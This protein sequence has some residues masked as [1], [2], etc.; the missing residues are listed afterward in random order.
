MSLKTS[1]RM[2][3]TLFR[4]LSSN[5]TQILHRIRSRKYNP[6]KELRDVRPEGS[7]QY[8]DEIIIPQDDLYIISWE[9]EF[10]DF[11]TH[12][13]SNNTSDTSPVDSDQRD[14]IITD[15]DLQSTRRDENNDDAATE[16]REQEINDADHR[17]ARP[18]Q[19]TSSDESEQLSEQPAENLADSDRRSTRPQ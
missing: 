11:P 14:A 6:N 13:D 3:I 19:D 10:D 12:S 2:K 8:D 1:Y 4:K 15:L 18:Q 16:Q 7:L 5:E 17:S 9:T